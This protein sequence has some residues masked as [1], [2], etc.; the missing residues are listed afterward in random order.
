MKKDQYIIDACR[1]E[2][3]PTQEVHAR[4]ANS[5]R[6]LH[7]AMGIA[8]EAGELVDQFKK[9]I[10]YGKPLDRINLIEEVGDLMWYL[11]LLAD[12]YDFGFDQATKVNIDKLRARFP[13][14]FADDQALYRNLD[15]EREVLENGAK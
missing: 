2:S 3:P 9:H 14:K 13:E 7:A 12:E 15:K 8:T 11:A 1:T 6:G 5:V 10:F 4:L